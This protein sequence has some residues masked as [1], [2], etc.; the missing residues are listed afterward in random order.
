MAF[1]FTQCGLLSIC[2][3]VK[4]FCLKE[5]KNATHAG[6]KIRKCFILKHLRGTAV[7][8]AGVNSVHTCLMMFKHWRVTE[9]RETW[10][11]I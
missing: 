9:S 11:G 8:G 6:L 1:Q 10:K 2:I 5:P 4:V 7:G 3:Y